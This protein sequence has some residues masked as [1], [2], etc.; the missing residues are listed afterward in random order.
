MLFSRGLITSASLLSHSSS[1][2]V[3]VLDKSRRFLGASI[4]E[5]NDK[6][7]NVGDT[8]TNSQGLWTSKH[9]RFK[10]H[11]TQILLITTVCLY[12]RLFNSLLLHMSVDVMLAI[13]CRFY[14]IWITLNIIY[15]HYTLNVLEHNVILMK[16]T[17]FALKTNYDNVS[18]DNVLSS[19]QTRAIITLSRCSPPYTIY[20]NSMF[21]IRPYVI[22]CSI[23]RGR[24]RIPHTPLS[25]HLLAVRPHRL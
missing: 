5:K 21:Y 22:N 14:F 19:A 4:S 3:E 9:Q 24:H 2:V 18:T 20:I 13:L 23:L 8:E 16:S 25:P 11:Q 6:A 7:D 17:C 10:H 12:V 1:R 15:I